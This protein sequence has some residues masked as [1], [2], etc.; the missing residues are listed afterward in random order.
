MMQATKSEDPEVRQVAEKLVE[1]MNRT[2]KVSGAAK[3]LEVHM[4]ATGSASLICGSR[5]TQEE[6]AEAVGWP[7]VTI[8]DEIASFVENGHLSESDKSRANHITDFQHPLYNVWS[9]GQKTNKVS[10]FKTT[11]VSPNRSPRRCVTSHANR[12]IDLTKYNHRP[13]V[14]P[15][16]A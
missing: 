10:H 6:I 1:E 3:K 12:Q 13:T 16:A 9:Y 8:T 2:G 5:A 7:R 4:Q 11:E 15:G 14:P